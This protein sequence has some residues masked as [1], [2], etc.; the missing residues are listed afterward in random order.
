MP[1]VVLPLTN[2]VSMFAPSVN[3]LQVSRLNITSGST[4]DTLT[5][6]HFAQQRNRPAHLRHVELLDLDPFLRGLLFTDGTVTRTLEVEALSRVSVEVVSQARSQVSGHTAA[7]LDA[8]DGMESVRRRVTIGIGTGVSRLPLIWA[9]SH[10]LP[11]RLPNEFLSVLHDAPDGIGESLQQVKLESWRDMLWF[12]L[13]SPPAWSGVSP[14]ARY[15]VI[16]RLYR[17]IS[18]NHPA[19]LISESIAVEQREGVYHLDWLP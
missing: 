12:G 7:H 14:D 1:Q 10:I 2:L 16:T 5:Q 3:S 18:N 6:R 17:V 4:P 13:D 9:E 8:P 19:L 15:E 11:I